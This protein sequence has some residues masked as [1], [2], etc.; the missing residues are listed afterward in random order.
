MRVPRLSLRRIFVSFAVLVAAVQVTAVTLAALPPNRYSNA[1]GPHTTYLSSFF[2]QNWRLF[3]PSPIAEDR[4]VRFQGSYLQADGTRAQTPWVD[5]TAV[6][7]DLV[8]HRVVG[9]RAGYITNKL[10]SPLDLRF[11]SLTDAE[12]AVAGG[13]TAAA[14]LSW[15]KLSSGMVAA[16]NRPNTVDFFLRYER[17]TTQL[18][19]DVLLA[20]WPDRQLT[21][22]RYAVR[23]QG[24]VPYAARSGT[25]AERTASRPEASERRSGWREPT[26]GN[27]EERRAIA[28]FDRRHR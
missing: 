6:E 5:W 28:S 14:P 7:L 19:T 26:P 10:Y 1:A 3:A 8:H 22:V 2:A 17:A 15:L 20:R 12:R 24:V 16:A 18:A 21:A 9:G 27:P 11:R 4:T 25:E 23:S 13:G